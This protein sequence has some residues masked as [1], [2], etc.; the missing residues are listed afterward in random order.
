MGS[1]PSTR[2]QLV[3]RRSTLACRSM[4]EVIPCVRL[5][6]RREESLFLTRT[7]FV[8]QCSQPLPD[9]FG[10]STQLLHFQGTSGALSPLWDRFLAEDSMNIL[11]AIKREERK[12]EKQLGKLQEQLE[13]VRAAGKALGN[14]DGRELSGIKKRVLSETRRTTIAKSP[15]KPCAKVRAQPKKALH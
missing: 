15:K 6:K 11:A 5:G 3:A 1:F 9:M 2:N 14:S 13:G 10:A 12:L 4:R 7:P 8:V